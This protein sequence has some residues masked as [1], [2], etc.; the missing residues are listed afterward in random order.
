MEGS[1]SPRIGMIQAEPEVWGYAGQ[2]KS[3]K[4]ETR[5]KTVIGKPNLFEYKLITH[6]VHDI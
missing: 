4:T 3:K 2:G 1:M 6:I 5:I